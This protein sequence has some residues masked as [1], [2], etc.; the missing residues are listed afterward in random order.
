MSAGSPY[1]QCGNNG[2]DELQPCS[3]EDSQKDCTF[4]Q[5][6][7]E[8]ITC[9]RNV[10]WCPSYT[11]EQ[12]PEN[13]TTTLGFVPLGY[14]CINDIGLFS[15]ETGKVLA[16]YGYND[17]QGSIIL[18]PNGTCVHWD[19]TP[20]H[21]VTSGPFAYCGQQ[22]DGS[23]SSCDTTFTGLMRT[24]DYDPRQRPWYRNTKALQ[25]P[26][27]SAPY[28]SHTHSNIITR[29]GITYAHPFYTTIRDDDNGDDKQVFAGVLAVDY[30]LEDVSNFLR[31]NY[32][33]SDD[34]I[35]TILEAAEPHYLIG[36]STGTSPYKEVQASDEDSPCENE[37]DEC[38]T[39][40]VLATDIGK[41]HPLDLVASRTVQEQ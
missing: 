16:N 35:V 14:H 10:K 39:V 6:A 26:S 24:V 3:D 4:I 17:L 31:D 40:R 33:T 18:I 29:I 30:T 19:G 34:I 32:G 21:R 12:V 15:Q 5:D 11:I 1:V 2:C 13:T 27:W 9:Q 20:V 28:P 38:V 8:R 36:I 41:G 25:K 22:Q 7:T 37:Q 23:P